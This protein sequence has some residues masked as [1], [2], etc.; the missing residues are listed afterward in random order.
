MVF[1]CLAW[2]KKDRFL[3]RLGMH[4]GQKIHALSAKEPVMANL[5]SCPPPVKSRRRRRGAKETYR[6]RNWLRTRGL[7]SAVV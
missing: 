3:S 1:F 5:S 6:I 2:L 7:N 4:I